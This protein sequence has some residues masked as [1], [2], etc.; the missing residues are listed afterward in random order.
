MS[1]QMFS[2]KKVCLFVCL[3]CDLVLL[4][5]WIKIHTVVISCNICKYV[6]SLSRIPFTTICLMCNFFCLS[7][8]ILSISSIFLCKIKIYIKSILL[9]KIN[10]LNLKYLII[11]KGFIFKN[12]TT[13]FFYIIFGFLLFSVRKDYNLNRG[14]NNLK[15]TISICSYIWSIHIFMLLFN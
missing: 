4:L 6:F 8:R 9:W 2:L 14:D 12:K 10:A 5:F 7:C 13:P 3:N 11:F 15:L 1:F